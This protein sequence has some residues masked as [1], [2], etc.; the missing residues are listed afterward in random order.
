MAHIG[1][2]RRKNEVPGT[3]DFNIITGTSKASASASAPATAAANVPAFRKTS[4]PAPRPEDFDN[5]EGSFFNYMNN[6]DSAGAALAQ[7]DTKNE[8]MVRQRIPLED[9]TKK[10]NTGRKRMIAQMFSQDWDPT[11]PGA[12]Q[13]ASTT[14]TTYVS[15]SELPVKPQL[16]RQDILASTMVMAH[17]PPTAKEQASI[18]AD[19]QHM[20]PSLAASN[21]IGAAGT[22][23]GRMPGHFTKKFDCQLREYNN[24]STTTTETSTAGVSRT[25][26]LLSKGYMDK[27]KKKGT[28]QAVE[29]SAQQTTKMSAKERAVSQILDAAAQQTPSVQPGGQSTNRILSNE[30]YP[31]SFP[32]VAPKLGQTAIILEPNFPV[33]S[34]YNQ[35]LNSGD[36]AYAPH[37]R[38]DGVLSSVR[39]SLL[40]ISKNR[41]R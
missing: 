25:S 22:P 31:P 5:R 40:N 41:S 39:H 10:F 28:T 29:S 24:T 26:D 23:R 34:P 19:P 6:R 16:S 35:W 21:S 2:I 11:G 12:D 9:K 13:R 3:G 4:N 33:A 30:P 38:A 1:S 27:V 18:S 7:I 37:L 17:P 14:A 8:D 32:T 20:Q 15:H 36:A